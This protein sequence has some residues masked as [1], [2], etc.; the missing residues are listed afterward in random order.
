MTDA[1]FVPWDLWSFSFYFPSVHFFDSLIVVDLGLIT[2]ISLPYLLLL[3]LFGHTNLLN[4]VSNA[5][6]PNESDNAVKEIIIIIFNILTH[7]QTNQRFASLQWTIIILNLTLDKFDI[8]D[9][10]QIIVC[11][12][13]FVFSGKHSH[14]AISIELTSELIVIH[15]CL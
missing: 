5:T 9:T 6:H 4:C 10:G 1:S 2:W 13:T 3:P 15:F 8:L 14:N 11:M 12:N 7:Q